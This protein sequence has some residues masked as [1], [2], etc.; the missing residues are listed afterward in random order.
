MSTISAGTTTT[1]ALVQTGDTT[2]DLVIKTNNGNTTA[3]TFTTAGS[4]NIPTA[5]ARITG[6]FSNATVANRVFLQNSVANAATS[7]GA[8]PNGTGSASSNFRAYGNS[9]PTNTSTMSIGVN[10]SESQVLAGI[11]GTGTYLPLTMFTGGSERL[12]I[13]TSGN[14]GIGTSSPAFPLDV[15]CDAGA[16]G[17]RLRG[18][19][20]N[21]SVLRFVS[22]DGA[23]NYGQFDVRSTDFRVNAVANIPMLF[24]TNNTE[25][26]RIT[27]GGDVG[28]GTSSV[29]GA[30]KL[31]IKQSSTVGLA[32]LSSSNDAGV[33][34]WNDSTKSIIA[35]SYEASA[36]YTPLTFQVNGAE[37][38][39]ITNSGGVSFGSSGTAYGSSGQL[40]QSNGDAAP[41]W[42]TVSTSPVVSA[43]AV[44]AYAMMQVSGGSRSAGTQI[45]GSSCNAISHIS[46]QSNAFAPNWFQQGTQ[47][48][49]WQC[50]SSTTGGN[51]FS[52]LIMQRIS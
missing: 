34:L 36:G 33:Y 15:Q 4:L 6:D 3:A 21:I 51:S 7:V 41:T 1:T 12:R 47:S 37:R 2:G 43:Y 35:S 19:S 9:D 30:T 24:S 20:D 32:I 45:A 48:G 16:F 18:R 26:V 49:T 38:M 22:N 28:I 10:A 5:G 11:T 46:N 14:V 25:R 31:T 13:D 27:G 39:R 42:V 23:T 40:L 50:M 44:G 29:A 52:I 8:I 17:L